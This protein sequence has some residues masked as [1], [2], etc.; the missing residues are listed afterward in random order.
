MN[1]IKSNNQVSLKY[2]RFTPSGFKDKLI[3]KFEFVAQTQFLRLKNKILYVMKLDLF[4][5]ELLRR[6]SF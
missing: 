1:S 5:E 2:E 3:R 4:F 6:K